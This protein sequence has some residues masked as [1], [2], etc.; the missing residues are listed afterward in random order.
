MEKMRKEIISAVMLALIALG[1]SMLAPC[2]RLAR[3]EGLVGDLNG[4]GKVDIKDVLVAAKA[5]GSYGPD[6]LHKGSPAEETWNPKADLN[7]DNQVN[8]LDVLMIMRSF[9]ATSP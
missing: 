9:G 3:A 1:I 8:L 5:F 4:D 6:F 7:G 2:I